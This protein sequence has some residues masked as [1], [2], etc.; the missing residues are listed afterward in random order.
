MFRILAAAVVALGLFG[1]IVGHID[2]SDSDITSAEK[3]AFGFCIGVFF[4]LVFWWRKKKK[5]KKF[6]AWCGDESGLKLEKEYEGKY[7]WAYPNKDG[8]EDK[9]K[10]NNYQQANYFTIWN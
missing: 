7:E 2:Y 1:F 3:W 8:S 10:R 5:L 4:I 6:C 9:R